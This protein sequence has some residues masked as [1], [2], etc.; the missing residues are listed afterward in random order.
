[1]RRPVA[2]SGNRWSP[3]VTAGLDRWS[4]KTELGLQTALAHEKQRPPI[5]RRAF[6]VALPS[7][8][9]GAIIRGTEVLV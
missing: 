8:E 9:E 5:F 4:S 7:G 3:P 6:Y 1:M 2:L